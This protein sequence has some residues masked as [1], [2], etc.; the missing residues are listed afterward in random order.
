MKEANKGFLQKAFE[1]IKGVVETI[2]NLVKMLIEVLSLRGPVCRRPHQ[3]PNRL[4]RQF[5]QRR[6]DR[7]QPVHREFH[8]SL[9][10]DIDRLV[11]CGN[12]LG[13]VAA[14]R[15]RSIRRGY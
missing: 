13:G 7:A 1:F 14:D 8:D 10:G 2:I 12:G 9:A 6:D 11:D 4:P 15:R 5:D 3:G